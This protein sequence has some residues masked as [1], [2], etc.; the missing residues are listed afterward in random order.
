MGEEDIHQELSLEILLRT[1][2]I[3]DVRDPND[4]SS[5]TGGGTPSITNIISTG[6]SITLIGGGGNV[7][8]TPPSY[9]ATDING[10]DITLSHFY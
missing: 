7:T 3:T 2:I 10:G 4:T 5:G 8:M 9:E 1:N 6:T